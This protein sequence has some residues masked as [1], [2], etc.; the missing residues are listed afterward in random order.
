MLFNKKVL[1]DEKFQKEIETVVVEE[2]QAKKYMLERLE[3]E[4][5]VRKMR[6]FVKKLVKFTQKGLLLHQGQR[7][8]E[9]W[10]E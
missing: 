5:T 10:C 9:D 8:G 7:C 6:R 4:V 2:Y 3:K 1:K